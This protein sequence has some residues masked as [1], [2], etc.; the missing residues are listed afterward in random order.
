MKSIAK[1]YA[2]LILKNIKTIE[3]VPEKIKE[4]VLLELTQKKED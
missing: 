2:E 3:D 1:I 4:E